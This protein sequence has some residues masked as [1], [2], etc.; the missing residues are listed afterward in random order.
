MAGEEAVVPAAVAFRDASGLGEAGVAAEGD[1]EAVGV[2]AA[3]EAGSMQ[4]LDSAEGAFEESD[5]G[6]GEGFR[7]GGLGGEE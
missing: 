5:A 3:D 1:E 7:G 6:G 2:E 4:F